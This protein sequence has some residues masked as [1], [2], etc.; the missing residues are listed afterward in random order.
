MGKAL[1]VLCQTLQH[2]SLLT[3]YCI[4]VVLP[5]RTAGVVLRMLAV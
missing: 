3:M 1:R 2:M 4:V 5:V